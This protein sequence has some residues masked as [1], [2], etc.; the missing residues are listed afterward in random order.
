MTGDVTQ[1]QRKEKEIPM[2]P[3][4]PITQEELTKLHAIVKAAA[5]VP[6]PISMKAD[7]PKAAVAYMEVALT[8][9]PQLLREIDRL[10]STINQQRAEIETARREATEAREAVKAMRLY[11]ERD[12][13]VLL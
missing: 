10:Q 9:L 4:K 5:G 1:A 8:G 12:D 7:A 6:I 11:M 3:S 2:T 13:E